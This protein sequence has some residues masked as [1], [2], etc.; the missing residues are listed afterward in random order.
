M[1][2]PL[3]SRQQCQGRP[4]HGPAVS[5]HAG[6]GDTGHPELAGLQQGG[7]YS[8]AGI[9]EHPAFCPRQQRKNAPGRRERPSAGCACFRQRTHPQQ[10]HD[11][12]RK[13]RRGIRRRG[14]C[15]QSVPRGSGSGNKDPL[16]SDA[17]SIRPA[18]TADGRVIVGAIEA[19]DRYYE[20]TYACGFA[21][22]EGAAPAE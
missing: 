18:W 9:S 5:G 2:P 21:L 1:L 12:D 19:F 14:Q 15:H 10:R 8:G 7:R 11:A 13:E 20:E 17:G 3:C 22:P 16:F 6:A 4:A